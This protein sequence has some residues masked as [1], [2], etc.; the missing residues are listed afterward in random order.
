MEASK[1]RSHI[2]VENCA[3]EK[4]TTCCF[5]GYR[6]EKFAFPLK[7]PSRE[8]SILLGYINIY[9]LFSIEKGYTAFLCGMAQGFDIICGETILRLKKHP[10]YEHIRLSCAVP[11]RDH[12][13]RWDGIWQL[14]HQKL[15]GL[16]DQVIYVS[17]DYSRECFHVR[18]RFMA[19]HASRLICYH[20]GQSGG[21]AYTVD[22]CRKKGIEIINLAEKI[23]AARQ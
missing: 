2:I 19:D 14:R 3:A 20:D 5:S 9:I 4:E 23:K 1:K 16:A 10:G 18:N 15:A 17:E 12:S 6:P 22:Y 11:Y 21:T 7:A 8:Y 13:K